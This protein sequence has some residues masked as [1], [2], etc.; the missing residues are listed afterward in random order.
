[1]NPDDFARVD[2]L[3][4]AS[5]TSIYGSRAANGVIYITTKRGQL[6]TKGSVQARYTFG[7]S[8]LANTRYFEQIQNTRRCSVCLST[9]ERIRLRRWPI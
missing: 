5:A 4:D 2:V 1:M 7:L 6:E 3:S 8:N 9:S